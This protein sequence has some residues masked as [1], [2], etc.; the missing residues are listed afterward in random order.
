M[1]KHGQ[2]IE[3]RLSAAT[4]SQDC[5]MAKQQALALDEVGPITHILEMAADPE[6]SSGSST[7]CIEVTGQCLSACQ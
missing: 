1:L 3:G 7:D 2:V 5:Q 6:D 4:K